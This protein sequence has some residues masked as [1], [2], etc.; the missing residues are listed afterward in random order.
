MAG[1]IDWFRWHHGSVTDPKFQLVAR[2]ADA[3]LPQVLSVWVFVLE[4]ASAAEER[5]TFGDIDHEAVDCLFGMD[6]GTT[7]AILDQMAVRGLLA[8]GMV[9]NWEKRQPKRERES[10]S[11]TDRVR[12]Y[13]ERQRQQRPGNAKEDHETP[14]NAMERQETPRE[15]ESR[16]EKK[17][18]IQVRAAALTPPVGVSDSVWNDFLK[19]RR[20]K[21]APMTAAAL[22]GIRREAEK[23]G[24][25]LEEVL[26]ECC[27]RGWQG[28][29]AEWVADKPKTFAQVAADVVRTTV[30]GKPDR[31]PTLVKIEEEAKRATP[32]PANIREKLAL[33]KG[34]NYA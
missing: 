20:A 31:D 28:F 18:V 23:A 22:D 16:E 10:D 34:A 15:E 12:A 11:S 25:S 32:I 6:D 30:P 33:L 8:D 19:I 9:A 5:G 4:K 21:K 29:K 13:R 14:C 2:K 26:T 1:G 7:A 3:T 24:W 17:K 27:V